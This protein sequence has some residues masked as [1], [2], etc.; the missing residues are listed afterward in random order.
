MKRNFLKFTTYFLTLAA[1]SILVV[2]A[3]AQTKKDSPKK[4]RRA[5]EKL[6][7]E[8]EKSFDQKDYKTAINKYAQA[9]ILD[10][11]SPKASLWHFKKAYAHYYLQEFDQSLG[12]FDAALTEGYTPLE[13]YKIRWQLNFEKKNFDAALEDAQKGLE[14]APSDLAFNSAIG[15]IYLAKNS[16]TEALAAF[17]KTLQLFPDNADTYYYSALTYQNLGDAQKQQSNA[18]EAIKRNTKFLGESYFIVGDA[19]QKS[20]NYNEAIEA[21]RKSLTAKP[22]YYPVYHNLSDIFRRQN[23]FEEAVGV[24][25]KAVE[26][27]PNDANFYLDLSHYYSLADDSAAAI[28]AARQAVKLLPDKSVGFTTLCRAYYEDKQFQPALEACNSALKLNPDDGEANVYLGFTYL[29]LDKTDAANSYFA[30]AVGGLKDY[31]QKN[32]DYSD[33]FYLLGNAYYYAN[34][35]QNAIDAYSRSLQLY[36]QFTKARFNLGLAYFVN[37]NTTAAQAQYEALLKVDKDLAAKLKQ[38]IDK[39]KEK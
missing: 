32:P 24:A 13:I 26:V 8:G 7:V 39:K 6:A 10:T 16:Y 18:L 34:Q 12:E 1:F 36:P 14:L 35:P 4:D 31:T 15:E 33:G 17:Q 25:K 27:F 30:K 20:Q 38:T 21:Y 3:D 5:A 11:K 19:A 28:G 23:N 29:S 9:T 37:G 22:D 2:E